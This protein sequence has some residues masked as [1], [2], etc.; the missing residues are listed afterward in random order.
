LNPLFVFCFESCKT[1][2]ITPVQYGLL[3]MPDGLVQWLTRR[4][5]A[6]NHHGRT[7]VEPFD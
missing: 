6:N 1:L 2:G 3:T 5:E 4:V 7:S